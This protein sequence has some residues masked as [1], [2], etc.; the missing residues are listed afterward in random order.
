MRFFKLLCLV[1]VASMLLCSCAGDSATATVTKD[2]II[3]AYEEAGY[4]VSTGMYDSDLDDGAIGYIKAEHPNGDYIYFTIYETV[5]AAQNY[6]DAYYHPVMLG[7]FSVIFG[8]PGW[9]RCHVHG[10]M[11]I[12]YIKA[13]V[14]D[15][16]ENLLKTK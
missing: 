14:Y 10:D 6:K 1:L 16:F 9:L 15:I 4:L 5:E 12:E 11:V 3:Q 13:N 7:F 8:E 2:E